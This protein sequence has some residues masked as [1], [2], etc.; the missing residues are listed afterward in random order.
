M[1]KC[2]LFGLLLALGC[3]GPQSALDPAGR[4]TLHCRRRGHLSDNCIGRASYLW[5]RAAAGPGRSRADRQPQDCRLRR[6]VVVARPL[7]A[8]GR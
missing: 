5:A 2:G 7:S 8:A 4:V 6:A 3:D 1:R